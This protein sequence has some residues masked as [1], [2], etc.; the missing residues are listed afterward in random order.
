MQ[1]RMGKEQMAIREEM[2]SDEDVAALIPTLKKTKT[3][4]GKTVKKSPADLRCE[5]K[6]KLTYKRAA[7]LAPR[8]SLY[9]LRHSWATNALKKGVDA[10]TVAILMGHEDPS[11]LSKVYQHLSLNPAH[12][13]TQAKKAAG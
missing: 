10:L 5:A 6:R 2:I 1:M 12:M 9:A 13:L 11:T 4:R 3:T 8:Y 7:E